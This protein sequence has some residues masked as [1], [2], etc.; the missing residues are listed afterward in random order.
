MYDG[1]VVLLLCSA[2]VGMVLMGWLLVRLWGVY[3]EVG[4]MWERK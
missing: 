4:W 2:G 1:V 3:S